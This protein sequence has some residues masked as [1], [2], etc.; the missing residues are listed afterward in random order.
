MR[1]ADTADR[2]V[3]Q[4]LAGEVWPAL[5]DRHAYR[6][7][8][9]GGPFLLPGMGAVTLGT[10]LG[11][12][13]TGMASDHLE[14]GLSVRHRE[15]E[16]NMALQFLT[17]VGNEVTVVSGA[18]AGAT[19][20]V[21]GQHAYVLVDAADDVLENV[22]VGDQVTVRARGQGLRLTDHPRVRVKNLDPAVLARMPGGTT[23]DGRLAV[24][25]ARRVPAEAAGAGGGMWSEFANTDLMGAYPGL[26]E[27][28]SLGLEDLR[29]G[30]VVVL[31]DQDHSWGRGY[32]PGWVTVGVI[33]TGQCSLF[34]H[35][36]G[37]TTLFSGPADAFD[38]I[39]DPAANLSRYVGSEAGESA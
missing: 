11:D 4:V 25:V 1:V 32:R 39:D 33:S 20:V 37:P 31:Q 16:A 12:P 17:C 13:A 8:A 22:T 36:P 14:P 24:H 28:L 6:V 9:D 30:D 7:D 34:G 21:I 38:L 3:T 29:V 35:G 15:P 2:L 19:G 10:H 23:D 18:A 5:G 27:D 26:A